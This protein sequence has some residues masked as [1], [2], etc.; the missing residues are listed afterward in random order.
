MSDLGI[1]LNKGINGDKDLKNADAYS[2]SNTRLYD[3]LQKT[4]NTIV[5]SDLIDPLTTFD[6]EF[7]FYPTNID[8]GTFLS[9]LAN[10]VFQSA[11]AD[12]SF[13]TNSHQLILN[14][15][16]YIQSMTLPQMVMPE[17]GKVPTLF[18]EFPVNNLYAKPDNNTF[19]MSILNTKVSLH[20]YL[21]YPWMREVTM[22]C[23]SYETQ[24]YTTATVTVKFDK[25][26][27][28]RCVFCGCRPTQIQSRQPSQE[29]TGEPTRDV[30]ML[31]D[32]MFITSAEKSGLRIYN[33]TA[34]YNAADLFW[35]T[36]K[37]NNQINAKF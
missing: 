22:P 17:A 26:C 7:A 27:N 9:R 34:L 20:D 18:G 35:N 16:F 31:F 2:Y 12:E 11:I 23:W 32:Y 4:S 14:L 25:H 33:D 15:G 21:F 29:P 13:A 5:A 30:T 3:F 8:G 10:D 1:V 19:T 24:P 36:K 6:V 28:S 37:M